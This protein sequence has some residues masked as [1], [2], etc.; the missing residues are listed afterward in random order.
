MT[1]SFV[2]TL[3]PILLFSPITRAFEFATTRGTGLGQTVVLSDP[4]PSA[5]LIVPSSSLNN[6]QGRVEL[7]VMRR[8]ELKD[9]DQGYIAAA[10]CL[11]RFTYAVGATQFGDGDLYAE[12]LARVATAFTFHSFTA[13][14]TASIMEI[15]FGG[16]YENLSA[17]GLGLGLSCRYEKVLVA[18]VAENLNWPRLHDNSERIKPGYSL[19]TELVG[20]GSYSVTGKVTFQKR[21]RPTFGVGQKID[22]SPLASVFWGLSTSPFIYGGGLELIYKRSLITY[23]TSYHPTL[24][25]T[26]IL[27]VGFM[28]GKTGSGEDEQSHQRGY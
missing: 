28:L 26:H 21:E 7:G 8:F 10:F 20:P 11:N 27:S 16:H 3:L 1:R 13:G 22:I 24:G 2:T 4:S 12:R 15:D 23:A 17:F 14:A 6:K 18:A 5:M 25:F 9:F 19:Y